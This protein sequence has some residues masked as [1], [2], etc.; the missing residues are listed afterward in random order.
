MSQSDQKTRAEQVMDR[1]RAFNL[2]RAVEEEKSNRKVRRFCLWIG[3]GSVVYLF[4]AAITIACIRNF[5]GVD[6]STDRWMILIVLP[7]SVGMALGTLGVITHKKNS[8]MDLNHDY[9]PKI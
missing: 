4:L 7:P 2:P 9:T 8:V 6:L 5:F 1:W 3:M